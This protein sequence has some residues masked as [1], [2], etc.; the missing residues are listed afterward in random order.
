MPDRQVVLAEYFIADESTLLFLTRKDFPEPLVKELPRS[1]ADIR[2]FVTRNFGA[3]SHPDG[4]IR[5]STGAKVSRLAEADYQAFLE[6]LIAPLAAPAPDGGPIIRPGDIVW[7]VPHDFLHYLPLHAVK[8]DGQYLIDRNPVCYT[9]NASVMKYCQQKR[10]ASR[11]TALILADPLLYT[12]DQALAIQSLFEPGS[13]ELHVKDATKEFLKRQLRSKPGIDIL[14][15][16]CH[17]RYNPEQALQSGIQLQD[18][19]LTAEEI[20]GLELDADL[21]TLSA[22]ESGINE[23]KPGDEL[24]GLSRA[25]IYAGTPS[26]VVSLWEVD[27]I[28]TSIV[29]AKFYQKLL[30]GEAKADALQNAQRELRLMTTEEVISTYYSNAQK[31]FDDPVG[32]RVLQMDMANLYFN[33]QAFEPAR[34]LYQDLHAT[35]PPG[36]E[37]VRLE[38]LMFQC[39][40]AEAGPARPCPYDHPYFWAPFVLVGDW[41]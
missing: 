38:N 35:A 13:A 16:A 40:I 26:V 21:V 39:E 27:A 28:S 18:E 11:K 23:N 31:R 32:S 3:E 5:Y 24:I 17:G 12:Q 33:V 22:C 30:A 36:P 9:P 10:K 37:R 14:H 2:S 6:D 41:R 1:G 4:H 20:F 15:I 7:F 34:S 19:L 8:L 29:M 25:L